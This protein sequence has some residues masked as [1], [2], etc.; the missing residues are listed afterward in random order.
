[1][2]LRFSQNEDSVCSV[3]GCDAIWLWGTIPVFQRNL[4]FHY[5]IAWYHNPEN[6]DLY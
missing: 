3:L 5:I 6:H 4:V 1:M 2:T